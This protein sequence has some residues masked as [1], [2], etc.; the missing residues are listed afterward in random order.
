MV[1]QYDK[2]HYHTCQQPSPNPQHQRNSQPPQ[3]KANDEDNG[4]LLETSR[5]Q[6]NNHQG[7][8]R[9]VEEVT[10]QGKVICSP[11]NTSLE[12]AKASHLAKVSRHRVLSTEIASYVAKQATSD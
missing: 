10:A 8:R 12:E 3:H 2:T 7:T 6:R 11:T 5:H 1:E 4:K 9:K